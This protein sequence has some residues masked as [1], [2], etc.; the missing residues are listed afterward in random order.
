MAGEFRSE[1]I[2]KVVGRWRAWLIRDVYVHTD[3]RLPSAIRRQAP[4]VVKKIVMDSPFQVMHPLSGFSSSRRGVA[5]GFTSSGAR[6][7]SKRAL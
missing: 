5:V 4:E 6:F 7:A 3:A 2:R 1:F